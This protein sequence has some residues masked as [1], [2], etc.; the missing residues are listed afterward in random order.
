MAPV[1][2][3]GVLPPAG[4]VGPN[5]SPRLE[6]NDFIKNEKYFSL[7]IQ[8]LQV[9]YGSD[10]VRDP[11]SYY[12]IGGIHGEPFFPWDGATAQKTGF[13]CQ[14]RSVLF[15]TWH[16]PYLLLFEQELQQQAAKIAQTYTVDKNLW[17]KAAAEL[18]Q[19]YWD[20]ARSQGPVPPEEIISVTQVKITK[21]N[22]VKAFVDNPF[23][24]FT[25]PT[26]DS[27]ASFDGDFQIWPQTLRNPDGEGPD[28]ASSVDSLKANLNL[29]VL[30][31][32]LNT[33][34]ALWGLGT[35]NEF[36]TKGA[37]QGGKPV[38]SLEAI[39]DTVHV[40]VGWGGHMGDLSVAAFDPIFYLHHCQIDRLLSLWSAVHPGVWVSPDR[41]QSASTELLPFWNTP[42][43]KWSSSA[44]KDTTKFNYTYPEFVGVDMSNPSTPA[45]FKQLIEYLYNNGA[46][47]KQVPRVAA[48]NTTPAAPGVQMRALAT[49]ESQALFAV[50]GA[51]SAT[52]AAN[53]PPPLDTTNWT[54]RIQCNQFEVKSSF[55]VYIFL[56][57]ESEIPNDP[58][59]WHG[60]P[61]LVGCN[62][63][64]V[65]SK[66]EHCS[67]CTQNADLATE[68]YVQLDDALHKS[69]KSVQEDVVKPYLKENLHW[70][71]AKANS[72]AIDLKSLSIVV[73]ATPISKSGDHIFPVL[74]EPRHIHEVTEG[75]Y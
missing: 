74:G 18:R 50:G 29:K 58:K 41:G 51:S 7:Y 16:R 67:N 35:W 15:P 47:P 31:L 70:R 45:Y 55:T 33:Y 12:Q 34:K 9:L 27:R 13:Y 6:I 66:P 4:G 61:L 32:R 73:V 21:P 75:R 26:D 49:H 2:I 68:G 20:W 48:A 57:K 37:T 5:V 1:I 53:H 36:S 63:I 30:N 25:F 40:R 22:G 62:D 59:Q 10:Y 52:V 39:H 42:Q 19:P 43:S 11:T 69:I 64:F 44:L 65:N 3:T 72:A 17:V 24:A 38:S 56:G 14:H 46:A 23:L 60:S 28:A 71:V 54:A 8:A